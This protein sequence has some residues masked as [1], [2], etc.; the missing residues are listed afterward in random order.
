MEQTNLLRLFGKPLA[1]ATVSAIA[2]SASFAAAQDAPPAENQPAKTG[3]RTQ[4]ETVVTSATRVETSAQT[5]PVAT[6]SVSGVQLERT[7]ATDLRDLTS[8]APNVNLEPVGA[9]QN[10]SA[11]FIRGFGSADIESATD[12]GVGVFIDGVYQASPRQR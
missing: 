1:F 12:P 3:P 9:F 11:F 5:T 2:L 8:Q 10:A 7:F 6:T 4:L